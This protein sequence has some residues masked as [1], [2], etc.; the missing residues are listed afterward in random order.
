M[1]TGKSRWLAGSQRPGRTETTHGKKNTLVPKFASSPKFLGHTMPQKYTIFKTT[2]QQPPTR[3]APSSY[4]WGYICKLYLAKWQ[5][6]PLNGGLVVR[7]YPQNAQKSGFLEERIAGLDDVNCNSLDI[8]G[9]LL[10][11]YLNPLSH[12][13]RWK[14]FR[15]S[16]HLL[17]RY[18]EDFGRLGIVFQPS[19][20]S[21]KLQL[22]N[23][24]LDS[25]A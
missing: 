6:L 23:R 17:T 15:G 13:L 25:F 22:S 2:L 3:W 4:K 19:I 10:R 20:I 7:E 11:R 18:L 24:T 8:Q 14:A 12:L 16:K 21:F 9:H 5:L 1:S